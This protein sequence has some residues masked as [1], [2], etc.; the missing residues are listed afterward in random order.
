[1]RHC[2]SSSGRNTYLA[3]NFS[4]NILLLQIN[5]NILYKFTQELKEISQQTGFIKYVYS[6]RV[7]NLIFM[8]LIPIRP[9][10][11]DLL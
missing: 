9:Y 11:F 5:Y 2:L 1:M 3:S 7:V 4:A 8:E 10:S 6:A